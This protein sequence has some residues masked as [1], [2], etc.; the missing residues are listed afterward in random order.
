MAE[1]AG[2]WKGGRILVTSD[3]Q[4]RYQIRKMVGGKHY[5]IVLDVRSEEDAELELRA[6]LADPRGY[7]GE[8][9]TGDRPPVEMTPTSID[10]F[11]KHLIAAGRTERYAT[12]VAVYLAA[13]RGA[14]GSADL[15]KLDGRVVKARL[16][17]WD[18]ARKHRIISFKSYCSWLVER[19]D[20]DPAESPGRFLT[21]P[22]AR[23]NHETK[24]YS[25]AE[26]EALYRVLTSQPIRDQ[27]CLQAKTG[28]HCS[29]VERLARGD[30]KAR[31]IEGCAPVAGT[32]TFIHKNGRPKTLSLDAQAFAAALRLQ[33]RG[34]AVT[35]KA[36]H[37]AVEHANEKH[38]SPVINFGWLRHSFGTWLAERGEI[39]KPTGAGVS[40][41]DVAKALGHTNTLTTRLHY[42]SVKVPPMYLVPILLQNPGD[43]P[44]AEPAPAAPAAPAPDSRAEA[45]EPR[46]RLRVVHGGRGGGEE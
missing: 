23:R 17:E 34:A 12:N 27:L 15:A 28:M 40:E 46:P 21:V 8:A 3:G 7:A 20:L 16:T 14:L 38:G 26:V 1:Q 24:G 29:E 11:R 5:S 30:W 13:W 36:V 10:A 4:T 2:K 43:P 41:E 32:V 42:L 25:I 22:S 33:E 44:V 18:T 35:N 6:F 19:G 45:P 37:W 31:A 9:R 39:F